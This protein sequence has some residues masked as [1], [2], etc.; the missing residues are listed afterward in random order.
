MWTVVE[1]EILL[2]VNINKISNAY[3]FILIQYLMLRAINYGYF[4]LYQMIKVQPLTIFFF[5]GKVSA[6]EGKTA[7]T[8]AYLHLLDWSV[9][10]RRQT[11]NLAFVWSSIVQ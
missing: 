11:T 7:G 9:C 8:T 2:Q 5:F 1:T 3:A 4:R 10:C 6:K